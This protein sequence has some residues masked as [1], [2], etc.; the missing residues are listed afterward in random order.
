MR[1]AGLR[2]FISSSN[3]NCFFSF[4]EI[5][6]ESTSFKPGMRSAFWAVRFNMNVMWLILFTSNPRGIMSLATSGGDDPD[7][8][9]GT[10]GPPPPSRLHGSPASRIGKQASPVTSSDH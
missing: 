3:E 2:T 1:R 8:A 10:E 4:P 6:G 5:L 9:A 7:G